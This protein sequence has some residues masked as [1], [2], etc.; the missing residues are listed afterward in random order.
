MPILCNQAMELYVSEF[1]K[2]I[3]YLHAFG[4]QTSLSI[5]HV[6]MNVSE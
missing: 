2:W 1:G 4:L 5:I 3:V 6:M